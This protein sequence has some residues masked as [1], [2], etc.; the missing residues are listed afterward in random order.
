MFKPFL[1]THMKNIIQ[2]YKVLDQNI[3][4][5]LCLFFTFILNH[6]KLD[7]CTVN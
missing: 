5:S 2:L 4:N 7:L 1:V 3:H 6:F